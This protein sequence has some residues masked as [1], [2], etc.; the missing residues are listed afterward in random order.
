M[1]SP[2]CLSVCVRPLIASEAIIRFYEIQYAGHAIEGGHNA[3]ILNPVA[4]NVPYYSLYNFISMHVTYQS[5]C[6]SLLNLSHSS[7]VPRWK[8]VFTSTVLKIDI[9]VLK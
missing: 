4:P 6:I 3:V 8:T 9:N 1:I 7:S 2:F 5:T